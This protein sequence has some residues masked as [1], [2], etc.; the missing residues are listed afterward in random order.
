MW[1]CSFGICI[2]LCCCIFQSWG[3]KIEKTDSSELN[4]AVWFNLPGFKSH[5]NSQKLTQFFFHCW[6][7]ET[8][9]LDE[10]PSYLRRVVFPTK[11]CS[12]P[13]KAPKGSIQEI[14]YRKCARACHLSRLSLWASILQ[15]LPL[16][17]G[18]SRLPHSFCLM[19][20]GMRKALGP[21]KVVILL[22]GSIRDVSMH[23]TSWKD[24]KKLVNCWLKEKMTS[25]FNFLKSLMNG[26]IR[27]LHI[28]YMCVQYNFCSGD[29]GEQGGSV[30][31]ILALKV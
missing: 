17:C 20:R 15:S 4:C 2:V 9:H 19:D 13:S 5:L 10:L 23:W 3:G 1:L 27:L 28:I 24:R 12:K 11:W 7:G 29:T 6:R 25:N 22:A 8:G 18:A 21:T 14:N 31:N 26:E 16:V 30:D